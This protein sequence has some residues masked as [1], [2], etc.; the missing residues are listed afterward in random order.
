LP[1]SNRN[2]PGEGINFKIRI[3]LT[4]AIDAEDGKVH[5]VGAERLASCLT[6]GSVGLRTRALAATKTEITVI[7]GN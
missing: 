5:D 6:R 4:L 2:R 1:S 7:A 3:S